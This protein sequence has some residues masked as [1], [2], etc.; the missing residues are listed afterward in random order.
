MYKDEIPS[1]EEVMEIQRRLEQM[2]QYLSGDRTASPDALE[3]ESPFS[4][5]RMRKDIKVLLSLINNLARRA[6]ATRCL[7]DDLRFLRVPKNALHEA[8][9]LNCYLATNK[10]CNKAKIIILLHI[11]VICLKT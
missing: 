2:E 11:I 10:S 7:T 9:D 4:P 1:P 3:G 5:K 6:S 8:W